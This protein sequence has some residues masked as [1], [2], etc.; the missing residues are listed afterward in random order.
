MSLETESLPNDIV[1][2]ISDFYRT[3][4]KFDRRGEQHDIRRSSVRYTEALTL[5]LLVYAFPPMNSLEIGLGTGGSCVA[6]ATT[7]R[8]LGLRSSHL[9]LDPFQETDAGGSGLLELQRLSLD[10]GVRWLCQRSE[11]YL[12]EKWQRK[13]MDLDFAFVDGGH[14][15]GQ[16]VTDAFYLDKVL[17]PGGVIAFHDGLL[18]STAAAVYFLVR[19]CGYSIVAVPRD[20]R[21]RWFLRSV[22]Y[23]LRLGWWYSTRVV[24]RLCRSLIVLKK[25]VT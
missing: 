1:S 18:I 2:T 22:R 10:S 15:V 24:P 21:F 17:R 6:I 20:G 11:C 25:P 8:H 4:L 23:G 5:A 3:P 19:E 13:E 9:A 16:K 14:Q 7:R 12:H